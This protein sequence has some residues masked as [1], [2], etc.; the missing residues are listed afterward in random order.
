MY[1]YNSVVKQLVRHGTA[2]GLR[3]GAG[4]GAAYGIIASIVL[5]FPSLQ[6]RPF[7]NFVSTT[8]AFLG[9]VF[10]GFCVGAIIGSLAGVIFGMLNGGAVG[11]LTVTLYSPMRDPSEYCWSVRLLSVPI[12]IGCGFVVTFVLGR[13]P[14]EELD[15]IFV[16]IPLLL[17]L[18]CAWMCSSRLAQWYLTHTGEVE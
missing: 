15:L 17:T 8:F 4:L 6:P 2:A 12:T 13:V 3:A 16:G 1:S 7:N 9:I 10:I 14:V 5:M 11:L 18:P